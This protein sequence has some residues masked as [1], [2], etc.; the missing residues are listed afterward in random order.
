MLY[1]SFDK[2]LKAAGFQWVRRPAWNRFLAFSNS[3]EVEMYGL[4]FLMDSMVMLVIELVSSSE[5]FTR[6]LGL[7]LRNLLFRREGGA[8]Y[9]T[10]VVVV[11]PFADE[12]VRS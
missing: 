9:S 1:E 2:F 3:R 12:K 6:S 5:M 7:I 11:Q 10:S 4:R 8:L